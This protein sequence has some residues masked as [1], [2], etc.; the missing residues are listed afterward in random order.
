MARA[1]NE[2]IPSLDVLRTE[3]VH[4][5][6]RLRGAAPGARRSSFCVAVCVGDVRP[7]DWQLA[8]DPLLHAGRVVSSAPPLKPIFDCAGR[9]LG[10]HSLDFLDRVQTEG[11]GRIGTPIQARAMLAGT[12]TAA[13]G[14]WPERRWE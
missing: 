9:V 10:Q 12:S 5:V 14:S 1:R 8:P 13:A 4:A 2:P 7:G 6:P 11:F 3:P